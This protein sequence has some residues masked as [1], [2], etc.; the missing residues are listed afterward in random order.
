M[1]SSH[2]Q[3]ITLVLLLMVPMFAFA[4]L[5]RVNNS[6]QAGPSTPTSL[7][8]VIDNVAAPGDTIICEHS[9]VAYDAGG[10]ITLDYEL[11]IFGTG[12]FLADNAQTQADTKQSKIDGIEFLPGSDGSEISG[13]EIGDVFINDDNITVYRNNILGQVLIGNTASVAGSGISQ[14]FIKSSQADALVRVVDCTNYFIQANYIHNTNAAGT[15]NVRIEGNSSGLVLNN[16]FYGAPVGAP[17]S[18]FINSY[19]QN[20]L[21]Q[22]SEINTGLSTNVT[23]EHNMCKSTFL[24]FYPGFN[25]LLDSIGTDIGP[26]SVLC[27]VDLSGVSRDGEFQL[28]GLWPCP[29]NPACDAGADGRDIGMFGGTRPYVLSGMPPI[30]SVFEYT[31]SA[32]GTNSGGTNSQVSGKS[33]R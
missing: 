25:I 21:F 28:N 7:Q 27:H 2:A 32:T 5:H 31:G 10:N 23:V 9:G 8:D 4:T 18:I 33:R 13:F 24:S 22:N 12:Y 17:P 26:D 19:V 30:P 15:N 20:N 1:Y 6:G 14:N 3:K 29:A 16:L 11:V